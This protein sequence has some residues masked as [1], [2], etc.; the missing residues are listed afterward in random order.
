MSHK[1][2]RTEREREN[3]V[4]V[5]AFVIVVIAVSSG[6]AFAAVVVLPC[7]FCL[8]LSCQSW[9]AKQPLASPVALCRVFTPKRSA[10]IMG[11]PQA[12]LSKT[13]GAKIGQIFVP[14]L[15]RKRILLLT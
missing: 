2:R 12:T 7:S 4:F 15:F 6:C 10:K 9:L 11:R 13:S 5:F 14:S 3:L 8:C 1:A